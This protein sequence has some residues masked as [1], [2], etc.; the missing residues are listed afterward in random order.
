VEYITLYG[1][2]FK[3]ERRT[4]NIERP[5]SNEKRIFNTELFWFHFSRFDVRDE[6]FGGCFRFFFIAHSKFDVGRSM[7][8]VHF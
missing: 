8:D 6:H 2:V 3:D 1:I 5:T 4:S 7:L